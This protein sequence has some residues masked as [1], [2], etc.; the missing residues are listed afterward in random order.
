MRI[1]SAKQLFIF[2]RKMLWERFSR[3]Q[4]C[5]EILFP[6]EEI[7]RGDYWMLKT[8]LSRAALSKTRVNKRFA[9]ISVEN[10][11]SS[12]RPSI[13]RIDENINKINVLVCVNARREPLIKSVKCLDCHGVQFRWFY[14]KI[15]TWNG[16]SQD[17]PSPSLR[18]RKGVST[19][20]MFEL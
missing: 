18:L 12:G 7:G 15:C 11:P 14:L 6:V 4:Y 1:V 20:G 13:S 10:Q 17:C 5:C 3:H 19:S 16:C 2:R 8:W 9:E